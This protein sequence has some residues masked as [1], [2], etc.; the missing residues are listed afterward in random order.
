MIVERS[1]SLAGIVHGNLMHADGYNKPWQH[2]LYERLQ[3][4]RSC[5]VFV[6]GLMA[7]GCTQESCRVRIDGRHGSAD[8]TE[9]TMV[10]MLHICKHDSSG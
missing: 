6:K 2:L 9:A 8:P 7:N 3:C 10:W 5:S 1:L 4:L